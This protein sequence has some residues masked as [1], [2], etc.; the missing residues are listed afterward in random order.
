MVS[1]GRR[2]ACFSMRSSRGAPAN[3]V[4]CHQVKLN[5][6]IPGGLD[7]LITRRFALGVVGRYQLLVF[8]RSTNNFFGA[9]WKA[10]YVW[11]F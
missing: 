2:P 3:P 5:L 9:F 10:E 8:N 1:S 7:Y 6:E 11:G 4:P